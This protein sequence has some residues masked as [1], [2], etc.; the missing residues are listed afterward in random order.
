[1]LHEPYLLK[2]GSSC[3]YIF[4]QAFLRLL[5]RLEKLKKDK[6]WNLVYFLLGITK[7]LITAKIASTK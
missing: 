3:D 7:P 1:M 4:T 2:H 6:K 5:V